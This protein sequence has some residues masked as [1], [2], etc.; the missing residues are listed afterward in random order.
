VVSFFTLGYV[1]PRKMVA[2]EVRAA[3]ESASETINSSL[4]WLTIQAVLRVVFG[5]SVWVS[6]LFTR[7]S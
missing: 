3:L 1:N 7:G 4:W 5:L 2:V 6:F